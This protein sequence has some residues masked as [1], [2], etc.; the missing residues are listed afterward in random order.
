MNPEKSKYGKNSTSN[1]YGASKSKINE[2]VDELK[3]LPTCL[4]SSK[5]KIYANSD[6]F[7]I[8]FSVFK[9]VSEIEKYRSLSKK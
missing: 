8:N 6:V 4:N 7:S 3:N 2:M 5:G 1:R 9:N